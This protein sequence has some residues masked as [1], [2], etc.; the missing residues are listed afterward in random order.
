[1]N[2]EELKQYLYKTKSE[3][4]MVSFYDKDQQKTIIDLPVHFQRY[5]GYVFEGCVEVRR[6][7][8]T[9]QE[10]LEYI[11]YQ[12]D[13]EYWE[14]AFASEKQNLINGYWYEVDYPQCLPFLPEFQNVT[15]YYSVSQNGNK[16]RE[17]GI[18]TYL[19][20]SSKIFRVYKPCMFMN[21]IL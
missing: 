12:C 1:M 21:I 7:A 4:F 20:L 15:I 19:F 11:H 16:I 13:P 2:R 6:H 10:L 9:E 18:D 17:I 8:M 14:E 3:I 5:D